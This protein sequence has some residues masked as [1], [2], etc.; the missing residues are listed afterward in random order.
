PAI[1]T[2][3]SKLEDNQI[4]IGSELSQFRD[5]VTSSVQLLQTSVTEIKMATTALENVI[6]ESS[7]LLQASLEQMQQ[8]QLENSDH[9]GKQIMEVRRDIAMTNKH[10]LPNIKHN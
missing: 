3:L 6:R 2:R 5:D 4:R 9:L 8:R 7:T 10:L 1:E